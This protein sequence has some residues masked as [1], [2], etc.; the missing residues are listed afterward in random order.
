MER[1]TG[2]IVAAKGILSTK[3]LVTAETQ[4][5]MTTI[6]RRMAAADVGDKAR[7]DIQHAR[8]LQPADRDEQADEEEQ[9]LIVHAA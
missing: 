9:R 4:R 6:D 7:D 2:I 5:M 1:M 3:A 8:L